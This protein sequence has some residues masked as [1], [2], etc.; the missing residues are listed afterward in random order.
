MSKPPLIGAVVLLEQTM[1]IEWLIEFSRGRGT[2][3][4][5]QGYRDFE[6]GHK[7]ASILRDLHNLDRLFLHSEAILMA[8]I[9]SGPSHGA[10]HAQQAPIGNEPKCSKV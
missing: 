10:T 1:T 2:S 4:H 6:R 8:P 5:H 9:F 7:Q 3:H